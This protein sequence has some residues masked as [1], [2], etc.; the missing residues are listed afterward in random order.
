MR[1][2]KD[3]LDLTTLEGLNDE[4]RSFFKNLSAYMLQGDK[5]SIG[6]TIGLERVKDTSSLFSVTYK[7]KPSYPARGKQVIAHAGLIGNLTVD[8]AMP[9]SQRSVLENA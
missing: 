5:A 1:H 9:I 8:A 3:T 6:I 7:V 2:D 4:V